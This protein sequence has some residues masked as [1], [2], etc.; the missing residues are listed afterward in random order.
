MPCHGCASTAELAELMLCQHGRVCRTRAVP[1]LCQHGRACRTHVPCPCCASTAELAE[2]MCS[3]PAVPARQSL[4][5]LC[6][7]TA[8]PARQSLPNSCAVPARQSLPNSCAMPLLCQHGRAC[9]T[10]VPCPC[11]ASTA[12]LAELMCRAE[13]NSSVELNWGLKR[14]A[15]VEFNC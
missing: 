12:E 5:N 1:L 14:R 4:P 2:L 11:C 3:A 9:R 8:V 10:H 13:L 15:T 6:C 7:A